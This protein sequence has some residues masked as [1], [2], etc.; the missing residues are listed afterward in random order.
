M[1]EPGQATPSLNRSQRRNMLRGD[2]NVIA[3]E[4]IRLIRDNS[5]NARPTN[6]KRIRKLEE[7][8]NVRGYY[9]EHEPNPQVIKSEGKQR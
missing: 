6:S 3:A 1:V 7:E 8:L 5:K 4:W 9:V 2:D